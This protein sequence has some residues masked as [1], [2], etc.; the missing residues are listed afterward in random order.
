[1][2]AHVPEKPETVAIVGDDGTLI[3]LGKVTVMVECRDEEIVPVG[4]NPTR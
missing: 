4:V 1:V 3:A 2:G